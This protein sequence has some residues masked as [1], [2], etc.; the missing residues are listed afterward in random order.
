MLLESCASVDCSGAAQARHCR[1]TA[2][3]AIARHLRSFRSRFD[4]RS[5][6][7]AGHR[8]GALRCRVPPHEMWSELVF[9]LQRW[10][11]MLCGPGSPILLQ[12]VPRSLADGCGREEIFPHG[13]PFAAVPATPDVWRHPPMPA[14]RANRSAW[15]T[16]MATPH[17]VLPARTHASSVERFSGVRVRT[18]GRL[19]MARSCDRSAFTAT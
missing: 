6:E 13:S 9:W 12:E 5:E 16:Q 10:A 19:L 14:P 15:C 18:I 1:T 7:P 2:P 11:S 17:W 4:F 8:S 3:R